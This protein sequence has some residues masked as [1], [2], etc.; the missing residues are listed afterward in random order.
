MPWKSV[1]SRP[2]CRLPCE[3]A[4][5]ASPSQPVPHPPPTTPQPQLPT[6]SIGQ[7][8]LCISDRL[9]TLPQ[10]QKFLKGGAPPPRPA[11]MEKPPVRAIIIGAGPAGL[12][13]ALHLQVQPST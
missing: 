7:Q 5:L 2:S 13:A 11:A 3:S 4:P 12:A 8:L 9:C 10:V 6:A 1:C